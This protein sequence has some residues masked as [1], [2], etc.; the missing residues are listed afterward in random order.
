V[1]AHCIWSSTARA[2][3]TSTWSPA[4]LARSLQYP[5]SLIAECPLRTT[6]PWTVR[7]DVENSNL[8]LPTFNINANQAA[9][10]RDDAL[11]LTSYD[12]VHSLDVRNIK[13]SDE[14]RRVARNHRQQREG[15]PDQHCPVVTA[16]GAEHRK[17]S[18]CHGR[19][20]CCAAVA[21][22]I[23]ECKLDSTQHQPSG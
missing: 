5:S 4:W 17:Q 12:S 18:M 9:R 2:I 8:L 14:A 21:L 10:I 11:P 1:C 15:R 13:S 23:R 6:C 3:N 20:L 19:C 7:L 22:L 16:S